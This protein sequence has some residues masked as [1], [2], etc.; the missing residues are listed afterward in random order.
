[1]AW[2]A[3]LAS[4]AAVAV[5]LGAAAPSSARP[6]VAPAVASYPGQLNSVIA[7]SASDA[8]A[9]GSGAL[10]L[11][12]NGS[13]WARVPVPHPGTFAND[14]RGVAAV[15]ASD[16]W[17]VGTWQDTPTAVKTLIVHWDGTR[18]TKVPS[19]SFGA[20]SQYGSV[21]TG[22]SATSASDVWAVGYYSK[23]NPS[24]TFQSLILHWDGSSW[25]RVPCP[26]PGFNFLNSV[27]SVS[28]TDAW[29]VGESSHIGTGVDK[30]LMLHW[31]GSSWTRVAVPSPSSNASLDSVSADS[32]AHAWAVG[33]YAAKTW[34][35]QWNGTAWTQVPTPSGIGYRSKLFAVSAVSTSDAWAVGYY[36]ID[37]SLILHWNGTTWSRS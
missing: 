37:R 32:P 21:L 23:A 24:A 35:L 34:A 4:G 20:G 12:W 14:L 36:G 29:A 31:D 22:V 15:S 1:M 30:G 26:E 6:A 8:W 3:V 10:A 16:V 9:V 5:T 13:S 2:A 27:T 11:H 25:T 18:W 19:P 17:A 33:A 7:I 28:A